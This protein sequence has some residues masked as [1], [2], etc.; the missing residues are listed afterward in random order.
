[1]DASSTKHPWSRLASSRVS[2]GHVSLG[3]VVT[4]T[5]RDPFHPSTPRVFKFDPG[6][7]NSNPRVYDIH[8]LL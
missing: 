6:Q 4:R 5:G 3:D 1:M 2:P 8:T 7:I